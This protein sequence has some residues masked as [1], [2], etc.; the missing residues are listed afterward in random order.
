VV[1]KAAAIFD[2]LMASAG[3]QI[4]LQ[5]QIHLQKYTVLFRKRVAKLLKIQKINTD[6]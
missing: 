3:L 1:E 2:M 6:I 5:I 4:H